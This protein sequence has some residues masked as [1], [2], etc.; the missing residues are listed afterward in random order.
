MCE[1]PILKSVFWLFWNT[2][3]CRSARS[4]I[5]MKKGRIK[6]IMRMIIALVGILGIAAYASNRKEKKERLDDDNGFIYSGS[7]VTVTSGKNKYRRYIKR[8]LDI[9]LSASGLMMLSPLFIILST[10]IFIDD[11]GMVMFKQK[12]VGKN[13]SFFY[14]HKFRTMKMSTPHDVPTHQFVDPDPYITRVGRVLRRTSLDELP[15]IWDILRG[16]M[17]VIGPRPALWNQDDLVEERAKYG[18]NDVT[19]GLTGLAQISGRDELEI[20]DK[21]RIDGEYVQALASGGLNAVAMD[22]KCFLGTIISVMKHEGVVEGGTGKM[23]GA[24]RS[25]AMEIDPEFILGCDKAISI[26]KNRKV[27]VLITGAGSYIGESFREYCNQRYAGNFK[28]DTLD[29]MDEGW[30]NHDFSVYDA[31]FHVA[32]IAH[33]DVENVSVEVR[34]KYYKVNTDLAIETARI[35]KKAGIKQ[36]IFMSSM[37]VYGSQKYIDRTTLQH[38]STFYGD[39]KWQADKG[40]RE[41][42][43]EDFAVAVLR[44]PMIYGRGCKGNYLVLS[45]LA[46]CIPIFPEYSNRRSMLYIE[47]LCEFLS[48]LL[49]SGDGGIY[50]PQNGEYSNTSEVVKLIGDATGKKVK[51]TKLLNPAVSIA[52]AI[53]GKIGNLAEKAFGTSYYDQG[54]SVYQGFDYQRFGLEES[55][56]RTECI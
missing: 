37:L 18:A 10:A 9:V 14:C 19:P 49:M 21:A 44:P 34:K 32:G 51:L 42:S 48:L 15:Q 43:T 33:A 39:S 20:H 26:D 35:A 12:R 54:L 55:I 23:K 16:K 3:R 11:P 52:K 31:V 27:R 7:A 56:R 45:K 2:G 25:G 53:P 40:V 36:F 17:S 38:P 6:K 30:R 41:L 5:E 47:N 46:K 22:I 1:I 24:L 29:M 13:C 28:I 4:S 50:F 8:A